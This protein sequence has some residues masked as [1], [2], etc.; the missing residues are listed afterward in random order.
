MQIG[1]ARRRAALRFSL[2]LLGACSLPALAQTS[3]AS[4]QVYRY[5][6]WGVDLSARDPSLRPGDD[7]QG[8][9]SGREQ[10]Q[11]QS[12][13]ALRALQPVVVAG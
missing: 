2:L 13:L 6:T 9:A 7:F 5:G 11:H 10:L 4:T 8:F 3:A 1:F 12:E